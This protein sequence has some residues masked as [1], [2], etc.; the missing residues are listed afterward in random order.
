MLA[1]GFVEVEHTQPSTGRCK[2][3]RLA[4]ISVL[5]R[6]SVEAG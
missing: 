6:E 1:G 5:D 3:P 4:R 2:A